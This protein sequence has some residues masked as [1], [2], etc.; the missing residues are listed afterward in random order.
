M[1]AAIA[2]FEAARGYAVERVQFGKPIG[3]FQLTQAKLVEIWEGIVKGH[4][5]AL[6]LGELEDEGRATHLHVSMGK[7][8][9]VRMARDAARVAREILGANGVVDDYPVIRHMLNMESVYTYE[10]THDI[11]TL[12]LGKAATGLDAFA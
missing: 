5:L 8:A 3:A 9:N 10:G 12:A 4:L 11:H 2:C 7:R 1:G 6:R